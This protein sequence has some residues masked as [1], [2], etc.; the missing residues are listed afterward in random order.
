MGRK[1]KYTERQTGEADE[2]RLNCAERMVG[3]SKKRGMNGGKEK[4]KLIFFFSG[5]V[6]SVGG[7]GKL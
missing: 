7:E 6:T 4:R 3:R 2:M 1:G 5:I